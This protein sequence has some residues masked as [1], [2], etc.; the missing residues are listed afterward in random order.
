MREPRSQALGIALLCLATFASG[1]LLYT[2]ANDMP[3][4]YHSDEPSKVDQVVG[5]RKL[6]FKHPLLLMNA[7]RVA[8]RW[9]GVGED[10]QRA[11]RTGRF[12]SAS[13]AAASVALLVL[14]ACLQRGALTAVLA[15][16][17]LLLSHGLFTFAHFMK[18]DTALLLG[19]SASLVAAAAFLRRPS[20]A[21]ALLL[22]V[23]AGLAISG[24][25]VGAVM[26]AVALSVALLGAGRRAEG[27]P[28]RALALGLFL[29]GLVATLLVVNVTILFEWKRFRAGLA[30][31]T[32][33]ATT[34]GGKPFASILSLAYVFGLL[35][36][37]TWPIR[38]LAVGWVAFLVA[39][40]RRWRPDDWLV[41]LFPAFY[42]AVLWAS[43]IK[44]VR[45]LLPVVVLAHLLAAYGLGA[46]V[47]GLARPG[48]ARVA[49]A[50]VGLLL[51]LAPQV[52][53]LRAYAD[54]FA[55]D[56]RLQLY[57]FVRRELPA[58]AHILQDRY[59]G[60]PDRDWGYWTAS[61]APLPQPLRTL[62]FVAELG[63]LDAMRAMGIEYV[64]V[65]GRAYERFF[66]E[67]KAFGSREAEE[68]FLRHK[69]VY[70]DLFR[71]GELVFQAGE[72][73]VSGA[74]VDPEVRLYRL[75]TK[76][77]APGPD[78]G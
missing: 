58:D 20:G 19:V 51:V 70:E 12:V 13:F 77:P 46:L 54:A 29:A 55:R 36:Q 68:R 23:G 7:T 48:R 6:N 30:Y 64:A 21:G 71:E 43:P 39:H 10:K 4:Y 37:S 14:L 18:E 76:G 59:A 35:D 50:A 61:N 24:K 2:R 72:A 49:A 56:S 66:S 9:T 5:A 27:A 34:G 17:I 53:T 57:D 75:P 47:A 3:Y 44:A 42:L 33:H 65:C 41:A 60:L 62:H 8:A 45:Y 11:A 74:P 67:H 73:R 38:I 32:D 26:L 28:G 52:V 25:Y 40:F 16:P 1:L 31:E 22:G 15:A 63:G 78:A 69:A